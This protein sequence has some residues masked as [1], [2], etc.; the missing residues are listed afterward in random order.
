MRKRTEAIVLTEQSEKSKTDV[1]LGMA[2]D[3]AVWD[4]SP[5]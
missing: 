4:Q 5:W 3:P 2:I 1:V